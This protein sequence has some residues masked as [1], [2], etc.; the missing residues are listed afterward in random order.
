MKWNTLFE[1]KE[2]A[3]TCEETMAD[4]KEYWKLLKPL[5]KLEKH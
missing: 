3:I 1:H 5:K 4:A 2:F